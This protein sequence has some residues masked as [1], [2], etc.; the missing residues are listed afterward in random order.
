MKAP[1]AQV[2]VVE[3]DAVITV[4]LLRLLRH[5]GTEPTTAGSGEQA[6]ELVRRWRFDLVILSLRL[7]GINGLEVCRRLKLD[8]DLK[9]IPV[10]LLTTELN[11]QLMDTAVRLG[12]VEYVTKPLELDDFKQRVLAHLGHPSKRAEDVARRRGILQAT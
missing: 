11:P 4:D 5:L 12:A 6:M 3:Q 7:H 8:P 9:D 1:S 10:I 2:L